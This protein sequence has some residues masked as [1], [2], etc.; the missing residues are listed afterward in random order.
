[1]TRDLESMRLE[2]QVTLDELFSE[3]LI[4]FELTAYQLITNG[5]GDYVIPFNDSR[6]HSCKFSW[7][8]GEDFKEISRAAILNRVNLMSGP[9]ARN[10][11]RGEAST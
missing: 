5:N 1:M 7:K 11:S 2:V 9:L 10:T 8:E 3:H 6:I 4:P